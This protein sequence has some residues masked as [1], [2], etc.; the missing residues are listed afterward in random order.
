VP[1]ESLTDLIE[2]LKQAIASAAPDTTAIEL[3]RRLI[4]RMGPGQ[5]SDDVALLLVR[6]SDEAQALPDAPSG[7]RKTA[8]VGGKLVR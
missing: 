8:R 3:C 2:Q 1:G 6:L 5:R 7:A 4:D